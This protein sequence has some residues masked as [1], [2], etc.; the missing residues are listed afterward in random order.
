MLSLLR[1]SICRFYDHDNSHIPFVAPTIRL[2][3]TLICW[4]VNTHYPDPA[5]D[6]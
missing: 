4:P 1:D 5:V 6:D 3:Q 2:C